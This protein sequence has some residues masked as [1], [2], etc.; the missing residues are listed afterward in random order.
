MTSLGH[1]IIA[2]FKRKIQQ[3]NF[4]EEHS[5]KTM[6]INII[7]IQKL[8]TIFIPWKPSVTMPI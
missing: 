3:H 5:T 4:A 8:L 1:I 2:I 7:N 6:Y